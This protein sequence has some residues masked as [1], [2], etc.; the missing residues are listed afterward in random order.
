MAEK[1]DTTNLSG[2]M[3]APDQANI[4]EAFSATRLLLIAA[5]KLADGR[6]PDAGLGV[7]AESSQNPTL[8]I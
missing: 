7:I 5:G 3:P 2:A 8:R 6:D 4:A 1:P